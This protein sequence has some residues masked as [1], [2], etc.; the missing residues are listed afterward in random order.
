VNTVEKTEEQK[1][2]LGQGI[3]HPDGRPM[4][5]FLDDDGCMWLCDKD[6]D[7]HKGFAEQGCWR[8]K[9]LAFTRND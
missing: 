8:C 9:D 2:Q 7:P 1:P 5:V 3:Y 6:I 4:Q